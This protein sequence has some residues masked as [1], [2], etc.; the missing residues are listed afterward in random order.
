MKPSASLRAGDDTVVAP[1]TPLGRSALAIVRIDGRGCVPILQQLSKGGV[2]PIRHATLIKLSDID[3]CIAVRYEGPHSFTG[4]DLIE[5]TLHGNPLLV[6]QVIA[7]C[8]ALGARMAE[9]GEFTE[10]AV[11]NGKMDLVQ[12]ESIADLINARTALQAKLSLSNLEGTLSRIAF[13]I[14]Q[15]LLEVIS[16][17][18]AALDF[19]EEGYEFITR[20]DVISRLEEVLGQ[21]RS[22]GETYRRGRATTTGL[23]AVILGRPNA[24]KS[25]LLN[26]LVG[27]DRAIVTAIPGTTRDIVRETI[28]IGGLPVTIADTAG[29]RES[30][31][32]VEGIGIER[33]R[34]AALAADIVL[35]LVDS[36]IG[37]TDEDRRELATLS[38]VELV[39]TK[40]D[41]AA[42]PDGLAISSISSQG[43]GELLARLDTLVR[44]RFAAPEGALVNERQSA[45][46]AEA[47]TAV[48]SA[49]D[50]AVSG[51]DEQMVLVDLY[52]GAG[53]LAAL[54]GAINRDDVLSEIFGKFCI[55]K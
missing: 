6:E 26:H 16:R 20:D 40:S 44:D 10:R 50:S 1:A 2:P 28:E 54:T 52:R 42:A 9:P 23:N 35:Y 53:A 48:E 21:L 51:L 33:A 29:L 8:V 24:G 13:A 5:L 30:S 34:Q 47:A 7:A 55:G 38:N 49:L 27:S 14:R 3:E 41:L 12:A 43:F 37:L 18:E 46:V 19:S 25:T 22:M 32:I 11:L 45:A 36:S 15:T 17:L 31:D 4:N 39:Y